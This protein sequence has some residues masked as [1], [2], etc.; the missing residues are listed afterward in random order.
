ML[1]VN[2]SR[3]SL[4]IF[5]NICITRNVCV[6]LSTI[7]CMHLDPICLF[8]QI[9]GVIVVAPIYTQQY[10]TYGPIFCQIIICKFL[11]VLKIL[12]QWMYLCMVCDSGNILFVLMTHL[13]CFRFK[14]PPTTQLF[15]SSQIR[16][17]RFVHMFGF[18]N[19]NRSEHFAVLRTH[20]TMCRNFQIRY[21]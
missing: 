8:R 15:T 4:P 5:L 16:C 2:L 14:D 17:T 21:K 7:T 1:E 13:F 20:I 11:D 3:V 18:P 12:P 19:T 6:C 10:K 9:T